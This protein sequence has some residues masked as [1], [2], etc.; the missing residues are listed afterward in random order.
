[1]VIL[2]IELD[3]SDPARTHEKASDAAKS[4]AS[5]SD[6]GVAI[7]S[8]T[9]Q[10]TAHKLDNLTYSC[11]SCKGVEDNKSL[12]SEF[13][14]KFGSEEKALDAFIGKRQSKFLVI[15]TFQF[16]GNETLAAKMPR[17]TQ[18]PPLAKNAMTMQTAL[19]TAYNDWNKNKTS[20]SV[21]EGAATDHGASSD[22]ASAS[23]SAAKPI[24]SSDDIKM[25]QTT[26][27]PAQQVP[28][29]PEVA[30]AA[31]MQR[32]SS[33]SESISSSNAQL[34]EKLVERQS[35][36]N[37]SNSVSV[38]DSSGPAAELSHSHSS[39]H[40]TTI[41]SKSVSHEPLHHGHSSLG[42]SHSKLIP[43]P[44]LPLP[45]PTT[46]T[47][48]L[49]IPYYYGNP[50]VDIF[51]GLI[52]IYKDSNLTS[53]DDLT[54]MA[55]SSALPI[56][57][58]EMLCILGIPAS[59]TCNELLNFIMPAGESMQY[60]RIIRDSYP[61][62][63]MAVLKF[64]TQKDADIFYN[65][66][67][68]REFNSIEEHICHLAFVE[69]IE[70]MNSSKGGSLP[71]PGFTE[72]PTCYI[73]L[74]RMDE[75]LNGVITILCN[76][77]FHSGCL[78]K[79]GDTCCPVCR[80][81]QT[82][83]YSVDNTCSECGSHENLWICLICG[84]VGCGRYVR[85]HAYDHFKLTQHTYAMELGHNR[86]WDYAADNYVHRLIQNKT[87]GK[88][89]QLDEGGRAV[90]QDEKV[91]SITLEYT[92]LLT[93]QLES[94]RLFFEEHID[95]IE[96]KSK[97]QIQELEAKAKHYESENA[98]L[99]ESLVQLNKEKNALEKKCSTLNTRLTKIQSDLEEEKELNKCLTSNQ[100][101]YQAQLSKLDEKLN[102][103]N[104]EKDKEIQDLSAQLRDIMFYLD[105][106]AKFNEMKDVSKEELQDS[107]TI[108]QQDENPSGVASASSK[109]AA[110]RK[111][112]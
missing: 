17:S 79:W 53:I 98:D 59:L 12:L 34:K 54:S 57:R 6:E 82:P 75:S 24:Q 25:E 50:T 97:T 93:S 41:V 94:Q 88:L 7:I 9:D 111:R 58:S 101:A 22:E 76:H 20:S 38:S 18:H 23:A 31:A 71:I 30:T 26:V 61:N 46:A 19:E 85:A 40:S 63:Y 49:E 106:Q 43:L 56:K 86:V 65:Y 2:R 62:R 45:T 4:A 10:L 107:H 29:A 105:S 72:L 70:L 74:E 33:N 91:D 48:T 3:D 96:Q 32:S 52:H 99:K 27:E 77:S 89:V 1:M 35:R 47:G 21:S 73:C 51:K 44:A 36:L 39:A 83:E 103:S 14:E 90:N 95:K 28:A 5:F 64:K 104:Q 87:D 92:Y 11:R 42:S 13:S 55:G 112:K 108:I 37:K 110:R 102:K 80:Y 68:N 60:V 84:N 81:S 100:E 69:R 8:S 66:Y 78:S 16:V 67:N 15:E 109:A